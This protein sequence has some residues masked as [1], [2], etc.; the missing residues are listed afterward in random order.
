[1]RERKAPDF[2]YAHPGYMLGFMRRRLNQFSIVSRKNKAEVQVAELRK[3][4]IEE[5]KRDNSSSHC[6]S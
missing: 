6:L 4:G 1:M 2:A 3:P 5:R